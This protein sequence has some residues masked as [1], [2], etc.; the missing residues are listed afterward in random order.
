MIDD[1]KGVAFPFAIDPATG[2]VTWARGREKLRQNI[3]IILGT[4]LGERP[5]LRDFG[6]R[7]HA[8]VHDPNDGV[9]VELAET[10]TRQ[11]LLQWE[12]R[13]L[14]TSTHVQQVEGE[15]RMQ[16]NYVHTEEPVSGQLILPLT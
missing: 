8:L 1:I 3:R 11:A 14:L 4:R 2:G 13:V 5:M 10:Q 15:V 7:L 6:S 16:L 12:P 9:L